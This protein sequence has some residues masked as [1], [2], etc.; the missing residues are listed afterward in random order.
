MTFE[1]KLKYWRAVRSLTFRELSE[2][3]NVSLQTLIT[4]EHGKIPTPTVR[5]RIA[6]AL[7]V[8]LEEIFK[9]IEPGRAG[10]VEAKN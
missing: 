4:V 1:N 5:R 2:R 9:V 6:N 8:P 10:L 3:S 7:D